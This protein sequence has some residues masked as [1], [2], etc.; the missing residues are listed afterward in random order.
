MITPTEITAAVA[1]AVETLFPGEPVYVD[2]PAPG[3]AEE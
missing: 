2:L 1:G 3:S